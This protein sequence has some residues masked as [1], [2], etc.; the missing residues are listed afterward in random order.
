M[1]NNLSYKH[2]DSLTKSSALSDMLQIIPPKAACDRLL[3]IYIDNFEN[4][5]RILHFT[6]FLQQYREFWTAQKDDLDACANPILP[7]LC[8]T[9]AIASSL[10]DGHHFDTLRACG[11][12]RHWLESLN[13]KDRIEL[14]TIRTQTLLLL[15]HQ[16]SLKRVEELWSESG[17]L[18]R[19]AMTFGLQRDPTESPGLS[20]FEAEQHKRLWITIAEIDLQ[21]ST[22]CGMP[23]MIRGADI[24]W[25]VPANVNDIDLFEGMK[26][27]PRHRPSDEW[28]D[29]SCQVILAKSLQWRLDTIANVDDISIGTGYDQTLKN[30]KKTEE[31]IRQ[32]PNINSDYT[33][34]RVSN[35][36]GR[37]LGGILLDVYLRRVPLCIYRRLA[38]LGSHEARNACVRSA[39]IMLSHQDAFDPHVADL[40]VIKS[41]RY[42]DLFYT[43]CK[44]DV[45]Q[46]AI[47]LCM[48]IKAMS[49][50]SPDPS[51]GVI[52]SEGRDGLHGQF[53]EANAPEMTSTWSKAS[54]TRSIENT[55]R[56]LASRAGKPGSDLKDPVCITI[57]LQS[58]RTNNP[59]INKEDL[60]R[61][62]VVSIINEYRQRLQDEESNSDNVIEPISTFS[63]R[64]AD[65]F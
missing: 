24:G 65:H 27:A 9:M 44:L 4:I 64:F 60:M 55:I 50:P 3:R 11:L 49:Q 21:I 5:T 28:T 42:W 43:F 37:L 16:T 53:V 14:S 18:V 41:E 56:S 35:G 57:I 36:S 33:S 52:S 17:A 62:G 12:V 38:L 45:V 54:L 47:S 31:D 63:T 8:L 40:D 1:K 6:T 58:V 29:S 46:A 7:Q 39:R 20:S 59:M 34:N 15:A 19:S 61:V 25:C 22:T 13:G 2:R 32:L 30:C 26:A 51:N 23:C 10:D 48:E